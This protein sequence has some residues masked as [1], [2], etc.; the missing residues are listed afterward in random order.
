MSRGIRS[1]PEGMG[2][3]SVCLEAL[4]LVR[5]GRRMEMDEERKAGTPWMQGAVALADELHKTIRLEIVLGL[6]AAF[7]RH[8]P[9]N[10]F[11]EWLKKFDTNGKYIL[12]STVDTAIR[13]AVERERKENCQ[14]IRAA[15]GACG[16]TGGFGGGVHYVTRDMATDAGEPQL[17]G[18]EIVEEPVE[19][20]YCGR[21]IA[22]IRER[23]RRSVA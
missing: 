10:R 14:A 9:G 4:P 23:A 20:E 22:A 7:A 21:P 3:T 15:C 19:C 8:W 5:V 12:R 18:Q 16:G 6:G 17:E 2:E 1:R 11:D 13:A